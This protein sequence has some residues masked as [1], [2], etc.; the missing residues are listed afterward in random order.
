MFP[1][2]SRK[3]CVKIVN[4]GESEIRYDVTSKITEGLSNYVACEK[5]F[6][7]VTLTGDAPNGETIDGLAFTVP[8]DAPVVSDCE[9]GI[10]VTR[11]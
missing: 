3:L 9:V 1:G 10:E 5:A 6:P 11:G 8:G 7:E 4:E 2:E